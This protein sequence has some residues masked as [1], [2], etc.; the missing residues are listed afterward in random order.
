MANI[1]GLDNKKISS[2][3][4]YDINQ[5]TDIETVISQLN[6]LLT[7]INNSYNITSIT[8]NGIVGMDFASAYYCAGWVNINFRILSAIS[9]QDGYKIATIDSVYAPKS[10]FFFGTIAGDSSIPSIKTKGKITSTGVI[11][12]EGSCA[13]YA[14]VNISYPVGW[15]E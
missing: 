11:T 4:I 10:D 5:E 12:I 9:N 7:K 15:I 13:S 3:Y 6:S 8:I 1:I 2:K 14:T